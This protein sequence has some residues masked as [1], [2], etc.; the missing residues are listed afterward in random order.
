MRGTAAPTTGL[1]S[2]SLARLGVP[3]SVFA[4]LTDFRRPPQNELPR[5]SLACFSI[6]TRLAQTSINQSGKRVKEESSPGGR[7]KTEGAE[8]SE[9]RTQC[10]PARD[11]PLLRSCYR[12]RVFVCCKTHC[13]MEIK[14]EGSSSRLCIKSVGTRVKGQGQGWQLPGEPRGSRRSRLR[15]AQHFLPRN[16]VH[17]TSVLVKTSWASCCSVSAPHRHGA[18]SYFELHNVCRSNW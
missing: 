7:K 9:S 3:W 6:C 13:R 15:N 10:F 5:V 11:L 1:A 18:H 17:L 14:R 2:L 8:T 4:R 16:S 12:S